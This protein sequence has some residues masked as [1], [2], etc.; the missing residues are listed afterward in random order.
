VGY[1]PVLLNP[2]DM[3]SLL[4]P[5][6][7][8]DR[9]EIPD[10]PTRS[11]LPDAPQL[12]QTDVEG[13]LSRLDQYAPKPYDAEEGQRGR[14]A[15]LL[16]AM[17]L[18]ANQADPRAGIGKML[19]GIGGAAV[20]AGKERRE[21]ERQLQAQADEMLREFG[22]KKE[23]VRGGLEDRNTD[24]RNKNAGVSWEVKVKNIE[25]ADEDLFRQWGV[26]KDE[27][28]ANAD[29]INQFNNRLNE[30]QNTRAKLGMGVLESNAQAVTQSRQYGAQTANSFNNDLRGAA[31]S[32]AQNDEALAAAREKR[33]DA[34]PLEAAIQELA[35]Y[36][37][38]E[39]T[40]KTDPDAVQ[41]A[42]A[43][44]QAVKAGNSPEAL[45][46]F[47]K[48][49]VRSGRLNAWAA[50]KGLTKPEEIEAV[51]VS[52]IADPKSAAG[53][54]GIIDELAAQGYPAARILKDARK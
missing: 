22:L 42:L 37:I 48:E 31:V 23:S 12:E 40:L 16:G 44:R 7:R 30:F 21:L 19:A 15:E 4:T 26:T 50:Q 17:A 10:V 46:A 18:A 14:F 38:S 9:I 11:A 49:V 43:V 3:M 13:R 45:R 53:V 28:L 24:V 5:P 8:P 52:F 32:F 34:D 20:G 51:V 35:P 29:L 25:R 33:E 47:G 27:V 54:S 1:D 41:T 36:G 6:T 39:V 2:G